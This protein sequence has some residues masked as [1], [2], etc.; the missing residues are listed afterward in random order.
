MA[1]VVEGEAQ[2]LL[3]GE[4]ETVPARRSISAK[5]PAIAPAAQRNGDRED[6]LVLV[7]IDERRFNELVR[8]RRIR[9]GGHAQPGPG[10]RMDVER[11]AHFV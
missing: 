7:P 11:M 9:A 2:V 5:W 8:Q 3:D 4:V 10:R 6:A 1:V